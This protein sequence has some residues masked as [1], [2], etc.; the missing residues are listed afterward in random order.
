MLREG[1]GR[2]RCAGFSPYR[3]MPALARPRIC[4]VTS[5]TERVRRR[6]GELGEGG[7]GREG[8]K[9]CGREG[10]ECEKKG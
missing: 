10:G 6:E 9:V 4:P 3:H 7:G 5:D 1:G 2:K 8:V